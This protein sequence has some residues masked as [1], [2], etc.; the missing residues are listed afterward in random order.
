MTK[1][2]TVG[3]SYLSWAGYLI[4]QNAIYS[5][6]I[7]LVTF[8]FTETQQL[9]FSLETQQESTWE[10]GKANV[11]AILLSMLEILFHNCERLKSDAKHRPLHF[12]LCFISWLVLFCPVCLLEVGVE[13]MQGGDTVN[14]RTHTSALASPTMFT[15][16]HSLAATV[17]PT[18]C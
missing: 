12:G 8:F 4:P 3:L 6:S 5:S 18:C 7:A 14:I 9:L 10:Q 2:G 11:I 13:E 1:Y 16:V 17:F 15:Q